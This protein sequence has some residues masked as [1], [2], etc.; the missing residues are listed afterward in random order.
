MS[1]VIIIGNGPAGI[2]AGLY[3]TRAGIDT[4]II[5]KDFGALEKATEIENYY[6]FGEPVAG[7]TLVNNGIKNIKRLGAQVITDEVLSFTYGSKKIVQ[8]K[9]NEYAADSIILATGSSRAKPRVENLLEFEGRGVSYCAACDG[10]FHRGND[11][12]VLGTGDYAVHE[13]L[14]LVSVARSVTILTNGKEPTTII[15]DNIKINKR[16]ISFLEGDVSLESV[17]FDDGTSLSLSGFFVALGVA[18]SADLAV[19]LGVATAD[20]LVLTDENMATNIPGV[21]AAG[22]CTGG[23][24]QIS[25]AVYE[26]AKAGTEAIEYIRSL[27]VQKSA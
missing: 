5:G 6:G 12:A 9:N 21:F 13:A 11:V 17:V 1:N 19:K 10:F 7:K 14:E 23:L 25:K 4:T 22:D 2:S 20:R 3:T 26:G 15:P 8:T 27:S 24:L 18:G 16:K